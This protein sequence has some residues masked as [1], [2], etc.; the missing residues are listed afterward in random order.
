M[1]SVG[2]IGLPNTGKSTLFKALTKIQVPI[3]IYPFTTIDPNHGVV[4]IKDARL[5]KIQNLLRPQKTTPVLVEFVDVAGLVR[6]AHQGKGLGNQFLSFLGEVDLLLEVVR[7]FENEKVIHVERTMDPKRD[8]EIVRDEILAR[9]K[10]IFL[11]FLENFKRRREF[12][13]DEREIVQNFK[14]FFEKNLWVGDAVEKIEKEKRERTRD[15]GKKLGLLSIKPIIYLFNISKEE[16]RERERL[17]SL[18]SPSLFLNLKQEEEILELTEKE[19][20]ELR[21]RSFLDDLVS[22]CYNELNLITFYTIKGGK[23]VRTYE[24][25]KGGNILGAAEKVHSDFKERFVRAEVLNF[26][27]FIKIG[28]WQ[29]AREKGKIQVK[30]KD[31]II[32]DGDIIE[33]KI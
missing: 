8:I 4:K 3:S 20:E 7:I 15:L 17:E 22:V 5:E 13:E 16:F 9:D 30:G 26:K 6:G 18:F 11:K 21:I 23:E 29:E 31:Y 2:I 24:I 32:N 1:F 14:E 28:S 19:K 33:F 10:K 12:K 27:D 25:K